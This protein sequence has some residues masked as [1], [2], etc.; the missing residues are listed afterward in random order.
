MGVVIVGAGGHGRDILAT[1]QAA[2]VEAILCD[3]KPHVHAWPV[4]GVPHE[5]LAAVNDPEARLKLAERFVGWPGGLLIDP[6][7][8]VGPGC[9]LGEGVVIAANVVLLRDCDLGAHVH[10][11]YGATMTR[12][13]I[14]A[15][16]TVAPGATI[17]GDVTIGQ[18]TFV[19]A[20]AVIKNLVTVGDGVTIGAGAVVVNDVPDNATVIGVPAR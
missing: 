19:G 4:P 15:F 14:G 11:N 1:A 8:R 10:V 6:S 5:Y 3:E 18:R 16:S 20:G 7:A 2:G 9:V 13:D 12:T 17:C